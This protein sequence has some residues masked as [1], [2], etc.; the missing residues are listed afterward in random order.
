MMAILFINTTLHFLMELLRLID[1]LFGET[2]GLFG[3]DA[4]LL[5]FEMYTSENQVNSLRL[6]LSS[7][8][9]SG[10]L[11]VKLAIFYNLGGLWNSLLV[12]KSISL[13]A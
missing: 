6:A 11:E 3:F 7:K 4:F 12:M 5:N 10:K 1:N 2:F 13:V 9:V 8:C